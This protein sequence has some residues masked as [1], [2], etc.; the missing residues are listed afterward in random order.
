MDSLFIL[1]LVLISMSAKHF[2]PQSIEL[3]HTCMEKTL[4]DKNS[5]CLSHNKIHIYVYISRSG[6]FNF[7]LP[8]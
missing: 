6:V 5:M 7:P 8:E 1:V 4:G 3:Q 2:A